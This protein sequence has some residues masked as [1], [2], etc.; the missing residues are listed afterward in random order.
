MNSIALEMAREELSRQKLEQ[1]SKA[2]N[3]TE[4]VNALKQKIDQTMEKINMVTASELARAEL[5]QQELADQC[6]KSM[7]RQKAIKK[8]SQMVEELDEGMDE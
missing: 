2:I 7:Q 8:G 1:E 4:K 3:A 6:K 5:V